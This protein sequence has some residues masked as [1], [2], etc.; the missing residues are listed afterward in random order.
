VDGFR[1]LEVYTRA[2]ALADALHFATAGWVWI[3][4][5][6]VG[7]QMMRAADSIG[8]NIAEACG[9]DTYADRRRQLYVARGSAFE[10]EHW[11]ERAQARRMD[12]PLNAQSE[13]QR[14]SRM[15]NGLAQRWSQAR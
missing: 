7:L 1:G 10:L 8:A 5:R 15:L 14:I 13:A 12:L 6:G 3:D 2:I 4:R 11:V 9:R